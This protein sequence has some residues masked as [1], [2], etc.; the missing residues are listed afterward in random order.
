MLLST[1][2]VV[3]PE[4][5]LI[6][7]AMGAVASA[8]LS[9]WGVVKIIGEIYRLVKKPSLD[10]DARILSLEEA[11]KVMQ[12][13]MIDNDIKYKRY[14]DN[15]N[16]RLKYLEKGTAVTQ[17]ALVALL[18]HG[19]SGNNLQQMEDAKDDLVSHM[20]GGTNIS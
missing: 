19:I 15:D 20:A 16:L 17:K 14:F 7:I 1:S 11:L 13:Q 8:I 3:Y 10:Q 2:P 9:I 12:Q 6:L 18:D 4:A 5:V